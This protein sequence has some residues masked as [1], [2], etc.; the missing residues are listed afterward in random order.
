MRVMMN[1]NIYRK[2]NTHS[3]RA[4]FDRV[5][6]AKSSL[7]SIANARSDALFVDRKTSGPIPSHVRSVILWGGPLKT[8]SLIAW[9]ASRRLE[10]ILMQEE[11]FN[12]SGADACAQYEWA[13]EQSN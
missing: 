3:N 10:I 4:K 2:R 6:G 1:H 12:P 11:S 7:R 9:M 8:S 13:A 5:D